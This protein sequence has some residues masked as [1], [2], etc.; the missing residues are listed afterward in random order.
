[1]SK[2]LKY[3]LAILPG[4]GLLFAILIVAASLL[5]NPND[6]KP[7]IVQMVKEKNQRTL[8]LAGDIKLTFFPKLG[9]DLGRVSL[10]EFRGEKEFAAVESARLYLSWW[11][12]LHKKL[13]VDQI[14]IQGLTANLARHKDGTT[15]FDDLLKKNEDSQNTQINF[16]INSIWITKS[17][18]S[19]LDKKT[20]HQFSLSDISIK[21][22]RLTNGKP[23]EASADF[24]LKGD[25][26]QVDARIHLT[27]G[28][29]FDTEAKRFAVKNLDLEI[30]GEAAG[31]INITAGLKGDA[32]LDQTADTLLMGNLLM[33]VAATKGSNDI[34]I[35]LTAPR[36]QWLEGKIATDAINLEAKIRQNEENKGEMVLLA[37]IPSVS[38][39][40]Q[41]FKASKVTVE[42]SGKQPDGKYQGQITSALNG[43]FDD[44]QFA[45]PSIKGTLTGNNAK[46]P[47]GSMQ[48]D[49]AGSAQLD[50]QNQNAT[51]TLT[52]HLDES[53]IKL[54]SGVTQFARP[55]IALNLD[56]DKLDADRYLPTQKAKDPSPL[57]KPL[58]FSILKTLNADGD[59]RIGSLKMYNITVR[60]LH[61][62]FKSSGG[63]M[64]IN[65]LS[66]DLYQGK[67]TGAISLYA[68]GQKIAARQNFSGVSIGPLVKDALNK[69]ILEGKGSVTIDIRAEGPTVQA[70]KK[71]LQG[72]ASLAL[73][74]GAVKGFN[75]PA[76]LREA[77]AALGKLTE[78]RV[79][80]ASM[81]EK[82]NFSD[83]SASFDINH[84][85]AHNKDLVAK[86]PLLRVSGN[87]DIDIGAEQI[88]YLARATV[89]A[90]LEG[91]GGKELLSLK[92]VTVPVR[93]SGPWAATKVSLDFNALIGEKVKKEIKT[94]VTDPLKE[95]IKGLFR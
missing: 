23:T 38:G 74:D 8:T 17:A 16:D 10:S 50:L 82:T 4:M 92:G 66:A 48:V 40:S 67:T 27:T 84:G 77:K 87:G 29:I 69:D 81:Q 41:S 95:G 94:R 32:E 46:M 56:I 13:V 62:I 31:L 26:P 42:L 20:A 78:E 73:R 80:S 63:K 61:L 30:T 9:L 12:L 34:N 91:Q 44:K 68:E 52:S 22:G 3:G 19:L 85:V 90:S 79:Q 47:G 64:D 18:F 70:M 60:N 72:K 15:N 36:L 55:H 93:I 39:D 49:L 59:I 45:L 57:D 71:S 25:T 76:K 24:I 6:Y 43:N 53:T 58:N 5:L 75:I 65:P 88:N 86:S 7:Q 37:S 35:K 21:T 89:L 51:L 1:M 83:L 28:L 33:V 2:Y 14:R 54:R 11:P